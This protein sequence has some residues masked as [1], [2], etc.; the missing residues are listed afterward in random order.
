MKMPFR[1]NATFNYSGFQIFFYDRNHN[2]IPELGI[3]H[4]NTFDGKLIVSMGDSRCLSLNQIE[5]LAKAQLKQVCNYYNLNF[6][7]TSLEF[8]D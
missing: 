2:L 4:G 1:V 3:E 6:N 5:T 7:N 8:M